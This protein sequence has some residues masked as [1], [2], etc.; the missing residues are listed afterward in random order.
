MSSLLTA[1]IN[2]SLR[3]IRLIVFNEQGEKIYEDWLPIR[4]Y[5]D[6]LK[7]EQD[8]NEWWEGFLSLFS[9]FRRKKIGVIGY[10][11]VTSSALCLIPI[12]KKGKPLT[13]VIMVSD[14]RAEEQ[15]NLLKS[16]PLASVLQK[17]PSF[18]ISP[19]YMIPK[20]MWLKDNDK[21]VFKKTY[22]FLS[23][24]DYLIYKLTGKIATD[25]LNAEKSY[26]D[27][28]TNL[29]QPEAIKFLGLSQNNFPKVVELGT[30]IGL[31]KASLVK[32]FKLDKSPQVF[33]TTYDAICAFL[34]SGVSHEGELSN[35]CGTC[36]SYR[37]FSKKSLGI[38]SNGI[39][40]QYLKKDK[41][42]I[43]GGSN[44]LEGGLL[45]WVKQCFYGESY[46]KD[47][48]FLYKLME[49]EARQSS[50]GAQG[51]IFLP[52]LL[53]ERVPF[54]DPHVRGIFFG[55]ERFHQ[56]KDFVRSAFEAT[57]F[58]A[59]LML[60]SLEDHKIKIK[61]IK[62]SGGLSDIE[63]I[64]QLRADIIGRPIDVIEEREST[65]LGAFILI[66]RARRKIKSISESSRIVKLRKT[67]TPN[68]KNNYLYN[69]VFK[70]YEDLY[71]L[72]QKL[73]KK[74]YQFINILSKEG[75]VVENL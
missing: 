63:L 67:F 42:F 11:S 49:D 3:S 50:L 58:Q 1:I 53:G 56:R 57:A 75:K 7:V 61:T 60:N 27:I 32:K 35:V 8:P 62:M 44:N 73:F 66:Q 68:K 4:T 28:Y 30:K 34:G 21:Q 65:A 48:D 31:L 25:Y 16:H 64:C 23:S 2:L 26:F 74:R 45:E 13:R 12:D 71:T 15:A 38:N 14:K 18:S 70:M 5:I 47:N 39:L 10:I 69:K 54:W 33:I 51:M 24:N 22:K 40:S 59:K 29:Y 17:N 52:Y 37:V 19:S 72:N 20:I 55:V 43:V 46:Q 6:G 36:S 41:L 9:G